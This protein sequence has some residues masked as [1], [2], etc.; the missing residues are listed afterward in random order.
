LTT[1]QNID[2]KTRNG[3]IAKTQI[4]K[5]SNDKFICDIH[6]DNAKGSF[7]DLPSSEHLSAK[8]CFSELVKKIQIIINSNYKNDSLERIDNICNCSHIT[9]KDEEIIINTS[10]ISVLVNGL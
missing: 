7:Y 10:S 9:K 1:V 2:F 3:L 6:A 8:D 4:V 5:I